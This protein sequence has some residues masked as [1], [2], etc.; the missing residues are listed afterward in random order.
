MY[1]GAPD[2][3]DLAA[4]VAAMTAILEIIA[5]KGD[6]MAKADIVTMAK[7]YLGRSS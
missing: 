4:K 6:I 5:D 1:G 7:A 3:A 2:H